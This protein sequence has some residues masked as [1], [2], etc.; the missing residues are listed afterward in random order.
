MMSIFSLATLL[1]Q[2]THCMLCLER[3]M[4]TN[5]SLKFTSSGFSLIEMAIVLFIVA[6]LLGGLLPTVG[7]Q[8]EQQHRVETR[9]QLDEILQALMGYAVINGHLPYPAK[10][11]IATGAANAGITDPTVATGVIPWATLGIKETDAWGR[12]FTY[13]SS[14]NFT[15]SNFTL[16]S[17]G[18]FT[19][20]SAATGGTSIATAIPAVIISHGANGLGAYSPAGIQISPVPIPTTDEGENADNGAN[21]IFVSHDFTPAFDDLVVWISPNILI[22]RMVAAGKLP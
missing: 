16:T 22:N 10:A 19:I 9:K 13:T 14:N 6:L 17:V 18:T 20:N 2:M 7:S 4:D 3:I 11:T 5:T 21:T 8:M 1:F 12:R 15:A